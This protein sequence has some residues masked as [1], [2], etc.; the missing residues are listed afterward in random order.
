LRLHVEV[1]LMKLA[2]RN[3]TIHMRAW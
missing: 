2:R 1:D 3:S